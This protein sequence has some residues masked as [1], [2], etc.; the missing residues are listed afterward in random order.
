MRYG[1]LDKEAGPF[2]CGESPRRKPNWMPSSDS[3]QDKPEH[4]TGKTCPHVTVLA[5]LIFD[6]LGIRHNLSAPGNTAC[7]A[8]VD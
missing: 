7:V 4:K 6:E 8:I 5:T 1:G 3:L 2:C